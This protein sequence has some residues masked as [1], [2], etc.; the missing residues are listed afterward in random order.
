M[1][2]RASHTSFLRSCPI[3]I[4]RIDR[5]TPT[6]GIEEFFDDDLRTKVEEYEKSKGEVVPKPVVTG[7]PWSTEDLRK[8]SFEDLH[9][10]WFV[11][12][13][14]R[15]MLATELLR[16]KANPDVPKEFGVN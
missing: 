11:L 8:K 10:L 15:N 12:L 7:K 16:W 9:K 14:E 1:G 5:S 4:N 13:K 6:R 3:S 2:S